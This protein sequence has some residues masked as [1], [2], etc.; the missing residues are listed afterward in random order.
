MIVSEVLIHDQ[1][2]K[3]LDSAKISVESKLA[4]YTGFLESRLEKNR[5][6][7]QILAGTDIH[8]LLTFLQENAAQ[9]S[10]ITRKANED[11]PGNDKISLDNRIESISQ[12]HG[13]LLG[14]LIK[15]VAVEMDLVQHEVSVPGKKKYFDVS[16]QLEFLKYCLAVSLEQ[17]L[18]DFTYYPLRNFLNSHAGS[19]RRPS[20]LILVIS[21]EGT[22]ICSA[23]NQTFINAQGFDKKYPFVAEALK[24]TVSTDFVYFDEFRKH[25][26]VTAVPAVHKSAVAGVVVVG[27]ALSAQ[28]V[29]SEMDVTG[30]EVVFFLG[31]K[32][33]KSSL[34]PEESRRFAGISDLYEDDNTIAVKT[35]ISGMASAPDLSVVLLQKKEDITGHLDTIIIMMRIVLGIL[36]IAGFFFIPFILHRYMKNL[37]TIEYGLNEII[38]GNKDFVFPADYKETVPVSLAK[39]LNIM[40]HSLMGRIVPGTSDFTLK[41]KQEVLVDT[42]AV[43]SLHA[44]WDEPAHIYYTNL[45]ESF[46]KAKKE[47]GFLPAE[48]PYFQ[49]LAYIMKQEQFFRKKY[50][51]K[52][53]RFKIG[54]RDGKIAMLPL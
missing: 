12:V 9:F 37:E 43:P 36:F 11:Y 24:G 27:S 1:K 14:S 5:L 16:E 38:T 25:Y 33:I 17:C 26:F 30:L 19:G 22:G 3:L 10:E 34:S 20:D 23:F 18:H 29:D 49:F 48:E 50:N 42:D 4:G 2:K 51:I 31:E 21:K 40:I 8:I 13:N 6:T 53:V 52:S 35:A 46:I 54:I 15:K 44:S 28:F 45:Y 47:L 32:I 7:G 39:S 41:I